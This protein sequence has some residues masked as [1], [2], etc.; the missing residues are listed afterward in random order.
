VGRQTKGQTR[1]AWTTSIQSKRNSLELLKENFRGSQSQ[2]KWRDTSRAVKSGL[3]LGKGFSFSTLGK[4][5]AKGN[6]ADQ[7][8]VRHGISVNWKSR[9]LFDREGKRTVWSRGRTGLL[10]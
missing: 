4:E 1:S 9:N 5:M 2:G 8:K 7:D 3:G 6:K 10:A